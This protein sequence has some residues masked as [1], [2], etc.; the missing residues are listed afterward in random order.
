MPASNSSDSS[1]AATILETFARPAFN[2]RGADEAS[3][4]PDRPGPKEI[5]E[6]G[7][8]E[9][10]IGH[11]GINRRGFS[12]LGIVDEP[13]VIVV[14]DGDGADGQTRH[15]H[16]PLLGIDAEPDAPLPPE[17]LDSIALV[18]ERN[19]VHRMTRSHPGT[20]WDRLLFSA[21]ETVYKGWFPMTGERLGF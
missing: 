2:S 1:S 16:S 21:K 9:H 3:R 14:E 12:G 17:V 15:H 11:R 8:V 5:G 18:S 4:Y 19:R 10:R 13:D 20:H 6:F 7:R